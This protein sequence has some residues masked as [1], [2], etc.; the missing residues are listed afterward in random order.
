M[1]G[2]EKRRQK[3]QKIRQTATLIAAER[4]IPV[5][6]IDITA[7]GASMVLSA[8]ATLSNDVELVFS[9]NGQTYIFPSTIKDRATVKGKEGKSWLRV[10]VQFN[11]LPNGAADLFGVLAGRIVK[12]GT[13]TLQ[14]DMSSS[15][16]PTEILNHTPSDQPTQILAKDR[17]DKRRHSRVK[18]HFQM[19]CF[20]DQIKAQGQ[21]LNVSEVG[22]GFLAKAGFPLQTNVTLHC[23]IDE[24]LS[25]KLNVLIRFR[26]QTHAAPDEVWQYGAQIESASPS[27]QSFLDRHGITQK[28]TRSTTR[29]DELRGGQ[30]GVLDQCKY[31]F[32]KHLGT[33]GFAKVILVEDVQ[34]HR[35][36]AMKILLPQI[37]EDKAMAKKFVKE[38]QISAKFHHPNIAFVYEVGEIE[39][40]RYSQVFDFPPDILEP[41]HSGM[42]YFT[43]Q[44]IEG[45]T[46]AEIIKKQK[47]I[48]VFEVIDILRAVGRALNFAHKE[49]VVHRDIKPEN[50]MKTY[51][52][53][54]LVTDFGIASVLSS[55]S[56]GAGADGL[57]DGQE[58]GQTKTKGFMGT[59]LYVSPEQIMEEELD[60]RCDL[61]S[62]GIT[63]YELLTGTT[64]FR[65]KTW[66]E[67]L[68]KQLHEPA[69]PLTDIDSTIP[70]N[71][72]DFIMALLQK[73]KE[74]RF[75]DAGVF[76]KKLDEL[77]VFL[78]AE[79]VEVEGAEEISPEMFE[80][81]EKLY[82]QFAKTF[83][84][85]GTYPETHEMV[86]QAIGRLYQM[87]VT[88]FDEFER[89]DFEISSMQVFFHGQAVFSED[90]KEN[91]FCF[92]LFRDGVRNL[93]FFRGMPES[94]L[95]SLL[96]SLY[97]Y[98]N[99]SKSYEIDAVTILFQLGLSFIDFEYADSFYEDPESQSRLYRLRSVVLKEENW[100]VPQMMK[101]AFN[102][103]KLLSFHHNIVKAVRQPSI[104]RCIAHLR[105]PD[106]NQIRKEAIRICL[107]LVE[108]EMK[109]EVFDEHYALM[110]EVIYSCVAE[111]DLSS[112]LYVLKSLESWGINAPENDLRECASRF[113]GLQERLSRED[114]IIPLVEKFFMV[115]RGHGDGVKAICQALSPTLAVPVLFELFL[116]ESEDWKRSFLAQCSVIAAGPKPEFLNQKALELDD[117]T[118]AVFLKSYRY[119]HPN[120]PKTTLLKWVKYNGPETR[121]VLVQ[122]ASLSNRSESTAIL[123]KCASERNQRFEESRKLAWQ[124]LEKF[125]PKALHSVVSEFFE[126]DRF[127][128]LT[129]LEKKLV[130]RLAGSVLAQKGG[131]HFLGQLVQEKGVLGTTSIPIEDRKQAARYLKQLNSLHGN[132]I[133]NKES[134]RLFGNREYLNYLKKLCEDIT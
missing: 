35:K 100:A 52:D 122:L 61:Y 45:R 86:Q 51:D 125:A 67:T 2:G 127:K 43:M 75:N 22:I 60:G 101:S 130:F 92:N 68:A 53:R 28:T 11:A 85:I 94:E 129:N 27:F 99:N 33:G 39:P 13:P 19:L 81:V 93:I 30:G 89:L 48:S 132:E 46:L 15:S 102:C 121:Q 31:K 117:D 107:Y 113:V 84:T 21:S 120:A 36:V 91:G 64:P 88:C 40:S 9:E 50:I 8:G 105:E 17:R 26:K 104:E 38:A 110:E 18:K 34:L 80:Y 108:Q 41:Y 82:R 69:A 96:V 90:Q 16:H 54:I 14:Q 134:K 3:R 59:P 97:Q 77:E 42:V 131:E 57:P 55:S 78:R 118:A 109:T 124:Y 71:F 49:G 112:A 70:V 1:Q 128:D 24:T 10:G 87:F 37:N 114:F 73:K 79:R 56:Q 98:I 103:E 5:R 123:K 4:R 65:G 74:A 133:L 25:F 7:Q 62:L 115:S 47:K 12:E 23:K 66:M 126:P 44:Y 20:Q 106:Y 95:R 32:I 111:N 63:G 58:S 6:I 83:K 29:H 76:L 119:L 72:N 116:A